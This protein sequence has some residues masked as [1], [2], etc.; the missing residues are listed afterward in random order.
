MNDNFQ[1]NPL[2]SAEKFLNDQ[3]W[4]FQRL[5]EDQL[6]LTVEGDRGLYRI[7][8]IWDTDNHALQYC[9]ELDINLDE[10][11]KEFAHQLLGEINSKLWLGHFDLSSD[12]AN[13]T[14]SPCFRYTSLMPGGIK[15]HGYTFMKELFSYTL[16]ECERLHEAMMMLDDGTGHAHSDKMKLMM[17]EAVGSC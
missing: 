17:A 10:E 14:C 13:T 2:E 9:C 11:R 4:D 15:E 5:N 6:Y 16:T 8:F 1:N 3:N 12:P 7:L